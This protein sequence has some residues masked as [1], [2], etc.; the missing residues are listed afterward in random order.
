MFM[1]QGGYAVSVDGQRR[2]AAHRVDPFIKAATPRI[3]YQ[4]ADSVMGHAVASEKFFPGVSDYR[5]G[6][7]A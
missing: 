4:S 1:P 2:S 6:S 7:S 3:L 5:L